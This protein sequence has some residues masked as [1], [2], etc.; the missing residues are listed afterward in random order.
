ML[1]I[2]TGTIR[3]G[4]AVGQLKLKNETERLQQYK[5]SLLFTIQSKAFSKI[6]FCE[7]SGYGMECF[8]DMQEE[9][10]KTGTKLELLS[11]TGNAEEVLKHGKGYGEGEIMDY[12]FANSSLLQDE[13]CF[14]KITG[15][16]KIV[17]IKDICEQINQEVCYFN[18]P[19]RTIRDYYDTKLYAMPT[20]M[21]NRYFRKAYTQVWDDKGI[22]LEKVYTKILLEEKI[23]VKNFT[24]YP[25]VVGTQGSTGLEYGY[26]EWKCKVRDIISKFGGYKVN[27]R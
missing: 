5:D 3:P 7:N 15:R 18:I 9:A 8:T 14:V 16:L 23:K 12:V 17:N 21:F 4:G 13:P 26:T 19:N 27:E 20:E 2:I 1:A 11:F 6:I 22:Y 10:A 24:R 25:R